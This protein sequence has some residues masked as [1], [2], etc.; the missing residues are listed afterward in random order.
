[1]GTHQRKGERTCS[2][3]SRL[4]S[5][6][7]DE[8]PAARGY[9]GGFACDLMLK[10]GA[11]PGHLSASSRRQGSAWSPPSSTPLDTA[12]AQKPA[13]P[14]TTRVLDRERMTQGSVSLGSV[15]HHEPLCLGT[16]KIRTSKE[17][18]KR[19]RRTLPFGDVLSL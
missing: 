8:V 1:M 5:N 2:Y 3:S 11:C 14:V 6:S 7:F 16:S 13:D 9:T 19:M 18:R 17:R 4:A 12:V 15:G 10:D